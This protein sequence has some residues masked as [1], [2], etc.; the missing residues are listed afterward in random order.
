MDLFNSVIPN[1]FAEQGMS[2]GTWYPGNAAL[3]DRVW[4]ANRCIQLNSQQIASMPVEW[5]GTTGTQ[6]PA[7]VSRTG[8]ELVPERGRRRAALDRRAV[9]RVG[10]RLPVR[11]R[12]LRGRVPAHLDGA[13][14][15]PVVDQGRRTARVSTSTARTFWIRGRVVQI[16]RNPGTGV[17]GTS[18]AARVC[19]AG[20]GAARGR[21][22]VDDR[23]H[24][25]H[26]AGGAEVRAEVDAGAGGGVAGAVDDRHHRAGRRPPVLPP[27]LEF[28]TLSF[29]PT[30]WR[31]WTRRSSTRGRSRRRSGCQR[32]C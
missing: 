1:W 25:R 13:G 32:C 6:E 5:H 23:Q 27:E 15:E 12:H 18:R 16:D 19:A 17:Q 20:V 29:N 4:V 2:T 30:I 21:E 9:V 28:E 24:R 7:W 11:H 8:P 22:P 3:T 14:L 26:P 10:V 31:C